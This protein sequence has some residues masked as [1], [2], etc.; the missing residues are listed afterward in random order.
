VLQI[1]AATLF[2]SGFLQIFLSCCSRKVV[3]I[4]YFVE[5]S[6][7]K[8]YLQALKKNRPRVD[9]TS[10]SDAESDNETKE[11]VVESKNRSKISKPSS[12]KQNPFIMKRN[13][14]KRNPFLMD[15]EKNHF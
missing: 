12:K 3:I 14:S 1:L 5:T 11:H 13:K 4:L 8:F 7:F 6:H 15:G 10:I 9:S 2:S